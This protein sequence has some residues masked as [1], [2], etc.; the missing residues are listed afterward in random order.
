MFY[1]V[2]TPWWMQR[3]YPSC[4]WN[5]KGPGKKVYLS[6][7]DGPHPQITPFV[8][9][10]L[11]QYGA[12]ASFFC[13]GKNVKAYPEIYKRIIDEG[14]AVGNHT[15]HHLNGWKN[16]SEDY[17]KDVEEAAGF[18]NS[19]LFR[20]PYG[21]IKRQQISMLEKKPLNYKIVMWTVLSGDFDTGISKEKCLSNVLEKTSNGSII[22]FHDSEKAFERMGYAL[23]VVLNKLSENGYVF[24]KISEVTS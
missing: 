16:N 22:V 21:K 24:E 13:I 6:F 11:K 18:I 3:L 7:D 15:Q 10:L 1:L 14:H 8:L 2:K 19:R 23:P 20:P 4:T 17:L 12:K 9:D 5:L